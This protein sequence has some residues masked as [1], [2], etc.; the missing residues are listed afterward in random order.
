[1]LYAF[2][3]ILFLL[4]SL[5]LATSFMLGGFVH[6]LFVLAVVLTFIK[7]IRSPGKDDLLGYKRKHPAHRRRSSILPRPEI[8]DSTN[9]S[10]FW[11]GSEPNKIHFMQGY[12]ENRIRYSKATKKPD[13][14]APLG[15]G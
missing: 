4:W 12:Q 11:L 1:M 7:L 9:N 5:A 8:I 10:P 3:L 6:L 2:A 15:R 13:K 14:T